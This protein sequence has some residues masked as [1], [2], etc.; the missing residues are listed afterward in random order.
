MDNDE[1]RVNVVD[2]GVCFCLVEFNAAKAKGVASTKLNIGDIEADSGSMV[3]FFLG[4]G[5]FYHKRWE[6]EHIAVKLG[7][8]R[9]PLE[10]DVF[11]DGI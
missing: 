6:G 8:L 11:R 3:I 5:S 10:F 4:H 7:K 9:T 1:D 2:V